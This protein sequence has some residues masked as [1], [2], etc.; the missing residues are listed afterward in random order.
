ML[1]FSDQPYRYFPPKNSWLF[2]RWILRHNRLVH[3]KRTQ[4]IVGVD[5]HH[6]DRVFAD[7]QD[8]DRLLFLVNHPTHA[9]AAI[10]LETLRQLRMRCQMMAAYDVFLRSRLTRFVMQRMGAF[11]VDRDGSDRR[12]MQQALDTLARGRYPLVIFPEGNVYL[13]NDRMTPLMDGAAF[14]A[15]K[16]QEALNKAD[17]PGRVRIVPVGIKATHETDARDAVA[18]R[19]A[20]L[21]EPL[22][23]TVD[24]RA[25]PLGAL[26]TVGR[27]ALVR[28]LKHRGLAVPEV[29]GDGVVELSSMAEAAADA[30]LDRL[31]PKLGLDPKAGSAAVERIRAARRAI[32]AVRSDPDRGLDH[33]AAATWADEAMLA[34]R[35][36]SYAIGYVHEKPTLDRV[37][38]TVEKLEEDLWNRMPRPLAPRHARVHFGKPIDVAAGVAMGLKKRE[39]LASVTSECESAIQA[40]VDEANAAN[41]RPGAGLF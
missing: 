23:K 16:A 35:L 40:L 12:P 8:G 14:T 36:A 1:E 24:L 20:A 32:H 30:V 41:T 7:R 2:S 33:A 19:L 39:L 28:N 4:Q 17:G 11:S 38:E 6:A 25:D 3:L 18:A 9:D 27:A 21:A 5:F 29:G 15:V 13:T 37:S 22:G 26:L 10:F 34:L 31:E